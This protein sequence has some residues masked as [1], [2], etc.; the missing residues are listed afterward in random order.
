MWSEIVF[1]AICF[2]GVGWLVFKIAEIC[3]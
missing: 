3:G 1:W 2:A